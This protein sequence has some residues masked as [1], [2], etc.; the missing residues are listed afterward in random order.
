MLSRRTFVI[1]GVGAVAAG[2]VAFVEIGPRRVLHQVG[3]VNSP[4]HHV[5][6]SGWPV[7]VP[8]RHGPPIAVLR[9]HRSDRV[10]VPQRERASDGRRNSDL[11][12]RATCHS[13]VEP[14]PF[15]EARVLDEAQQ[16][17]L[18]R[19]EPPASFF[20]AQCIQR[21]VQRM[22]VLVDELLDPLVQSV[23]PITS[24]SHGATLR[25]LRVDRRRRALS[26]KLGEC[27]LAERL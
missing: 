25:A 20:L 12:G 8:S 18:R 5:P 3:L 24:L 22:P 10:G 27:C 4:D 15:D 11:L 2:G 13:L 19:H 16:R 17:R 14:H 21:V 7:E 26:A 1:G 23:G 6:E 9:L